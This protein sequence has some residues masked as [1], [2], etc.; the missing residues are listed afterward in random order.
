MRL[1][2]CPL[3]KISSNLAN[4]E[5]ENCLS[6]EPALPALPSYLPSFPALVPQSS[7]LPHVLEVAPNANPLLLV[8]QN[9]DPDS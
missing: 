9:L 6:P 4:I 2:V 7:A 8:D 5:L 1:P 3:S